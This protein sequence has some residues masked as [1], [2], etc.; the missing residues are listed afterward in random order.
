MVSQYSSS[1]WN[2][3]FWRWDNLNKRVDQS[4][5]SINS[6]AFYGFGSRILIYNWHEP[7]LDVS[8]WSKFILL[9]TFENTLITQRQDATNVSSLPS[10]WFL[11][12]FFCLFGLN[13]Y[14]V[15]TRWTHVIAKQ[16]HRWSN[17]LVYQET[18]SS[19]RALLAVT[20]NQA[21]VQHQSTHYTFWPK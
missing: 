8:I 5:P 1:W 10:F 13:M 17:L 18:A 14:W 21:S 19:Q 16:F 7:L 6:L 20:F 2:T 11:S 15:T 3:L 12:W 9:G 4:N